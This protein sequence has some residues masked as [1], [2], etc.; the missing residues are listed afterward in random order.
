MCVKYIKLLIFTCCSYAKKWSVEQRKFY[1]VQK[2]E[3]F[4]ADRA[5]NEKTAMTLHSN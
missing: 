4:E 2:I 5:L 3:Y 1:L